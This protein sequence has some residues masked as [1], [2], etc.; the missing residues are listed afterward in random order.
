MARTVPIWSDAY[1]NW[2]GAPW[3]N[4]QEWAPWYTPLSGRIQV[5]EAGP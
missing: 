2:Q 3:G 1:K 4:W 5:E